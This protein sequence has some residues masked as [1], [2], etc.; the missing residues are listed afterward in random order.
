MLT[1]VLLHSS[2]FDFLDTA[3][4]RYPELPSRMAVSALDGHSLFSA[5]PIWASAPGH[6]LQQLTPR[7]PAMSSALEHTA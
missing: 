5:I 2:P 7:P 1:D 3:Q 4:L 6:H